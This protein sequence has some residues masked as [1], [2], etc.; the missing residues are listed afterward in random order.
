MTEG[1]LGLPESAATLI[2]GADGG[3]LPNPA[4][5]LLRVLPAAPDHLDA[6]RDVHNEIIPTAPLSPEEVVER[7]R[8]NRL[9]V[10]Y[11][12]AVLVGCATVRPPQ[13]G[14]VTVIVRI[15]APFR[16]RGLGSTYVERVMAD[17]RELRPDRIETVVLGSN[18]DGLRFAE[19]HGFAEHHRYLLPGHTVPFVDLHLVG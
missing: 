10:A 18:V 3:G 16:R 15:L 11:V 12:G 7:S 9:T 17:V 2:V 19:R 5:D 6:W 13:D 14:A 1:G 8:R 4:A